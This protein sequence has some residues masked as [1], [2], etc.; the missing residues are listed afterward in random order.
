VL[1]KCTKE[2]GKRCGMQ[3][4]ED[5]GMGGYHE[6]VQSSVHGSRKKRNQK[7]ETKKRKDE[8]NKNTRNQKETESTKGKR[9]GVEQE[10]GRQWRGTIPL[11]P[12]STVY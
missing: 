9:G 3:Q 7:K 4:P 8:Q 5:E 2:R 6:N 10:G 1:D 12:P 11:K